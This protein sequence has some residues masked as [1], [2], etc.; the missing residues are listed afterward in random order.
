MVMP[1]AKVDVAGCAWPYL[2]YKTGVVRYVEVAPIRDQ[3]G[4]WVADYS[5]EF[6]EEFRGGWDC[7][8]RCLTGKGMIIGQQHL[9]LVQ[10]AEVLEDAK[11][12]SS[13]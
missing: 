2:Q 6:D 1:R 7:Y 12:E 5:V 8:S 11:V 13:A 10:Y 9:E 3:P 4:A